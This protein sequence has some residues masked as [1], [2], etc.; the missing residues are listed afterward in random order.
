MRTK[1]AI[2]CSGWG[3]NAIDVMEEYFCN[4]EVSENFEIALLIYDAE[5]CGAAQTA[6][7][8]GIETLQIKRSDFNNYEEHQ[9]ELIIEL[10]RRE[11]DFIFMMNY[12]YLIR[13]DMLNSFPNQIINIHPSLFPSFLAT[14]TAIQ[15]AISY[16]VK[17]TGITTHRIDHEY[18]KG[19]ILFQVP[20]KVNS[21]DSFDTLYPK[22]KKKGKK[23][24]LQTMLGISNNYTKNN[25]R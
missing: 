19:E 15:D 2:L 13:K 11:I 9:Q 12:K 23:I 6:Q 17:I 21:E 8:A 24:I 25:P 20:I 16:G 4:E 7:K 1:W 14:K 18:D 10:K 5:Q 22:F 3:A